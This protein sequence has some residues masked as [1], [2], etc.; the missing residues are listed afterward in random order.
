[1]SLLYGWPYK[2]VI[3][4]A[5]VGWWGGKVVGQSDC[6]PSY[7][8]SLQGGAVLGPNLDSDDV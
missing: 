6:R 8:A 5:V 3:G 2:T 1:L 7:A 4:Y